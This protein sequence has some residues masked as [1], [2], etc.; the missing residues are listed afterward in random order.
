MIVD[1]PHA[2]ETTLADQLLAHY[3]RHARALPWRSPPHTPPPPPYRVWLSEIMLQQTTV[4]AVI[5][6]FE[7]FCTRWPSVDKLAEAADD[8]V[9]AAWAGLGY[10]SR[11]RN[12]LACARA[13]IANHNHMFPNNAAQLQDLPGIGPYTSAAIAAIAFGER[14]AVLDAN[15]ERVIARLYAIDTPLPAAKNEMREKLFAITPAHRPGDFA[16]GMMDLGASLCSVKKPACPLCPFAQNCMAYAAGDMETYPVKPPKKA[17]PERKGL[18]YYIERDEKIWI[19]QRPQTGMLAAMAALPDDGWSAQKDGRGDLP[20]GADWQILPAPIVHIF[21][22]ARLELSVAITRWA[23]DAPDPTA[24]GRWISKAALPAAGLPTLY[25]KAVKS[26]EKYLAKA[27]KPA[28]PQ[29][30]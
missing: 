15:V 25:A 1:R 23:D 24:H 7:K 12:L 13:V 21:T 9:M 6:Y 5:P 3:D 18:A 2:K 27:D 20:S 14:T 8:D 30:G 29:K 26:V 11:A 22:H 10:Y 19:I 4:T 16:Q 17:R 28:T